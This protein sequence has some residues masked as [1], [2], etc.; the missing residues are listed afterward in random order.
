MPNISEQ[1]NLWFSLGIANEEEERVLLLALNFYKDNGRVTE[2]ASAVASRLIER[3]LKE[4]IANRL[5]KP[6]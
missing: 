6:G 2:N 1:S 5:K 3:T 4:S